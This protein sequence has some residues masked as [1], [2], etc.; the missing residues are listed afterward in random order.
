MKKIYLFLFGNFFF[1]CTGF[2]QT[3]TVPIQ[4]PGFDN[5]STFA[6]N[7]WTV[8][9][10]AGGNDWVVGSAAFHSAPNSAYISTDGNPKNY[11]YDNTKAHI[12]HFYQ[13][14]S[15]PANAMNI[16]FSFQLLGNNQLD[17][18]LT[19][20]DGLQIFADTSLT[21]PV[22]DVMP[23]GSAQQVFFQFSQNTSYTGQTVTLDALG[24]GGKSFLLI[25]TWLNDGDGAGSGPPASVD[26]ASI[27][28]CLKSSKFN[29]TG[30]GAFCTGSSGVG[31][32]LAGSTI[33]ISYQLYDNGT[34]IG[35]PVTGTGSA[36]DFGPQTAVGTYTV[37]GSSTCI[38]GTYTFPMPG[39]ATVTKNSLPVA[40][41][42]SNAPIC[43]GSTLNLTAGG[44]TSYKWI[45]PNGFTSTIQ[46]PAIANFS[47][48][49]TGTYTVTVMANGCSAPAT[50]RVSVTAGS[51][52]A[53]TLN[54]VSV[55]KGSNGKLILSGNSNN[56][57]YWQSTTDTTS[58]TWSKIDSTGSSL[59]LTNITIPAFYRAV[60]SDGC[61]TASSSIATV[62]IH[63]LWTGVSGTNWNDTGN[64]SDGKL[65]STSCPTV[66]IPV[67]PT[68]KYPLLSTGPIA[69]IIN[70]QIDANASLTIQGD[71][72]QIA[73]N[74]SNSGTFDVRSGSIEFN[75]GTPQNI[76]G[77]IF[78]THVIQNLIVSNATGLSVLA[79]GGTL[80]ISGTLSFGNA[81]GKLS[82]GDNITLLSTVNGTANTGVMSNTNTITGKVTVNRF[83]N[84]GT[85]GN[86]HGK[87]WQLLAT[88]TV[89][90]TIR[91][92]WMEGAAA[93][94]VTAK[95]AAGP[96]NP[97]PGYGTMTTSDV[98]NAGNFPTP[99]F[100][101]YT[102][103]GPSIKVYNYL[104]NNY[105]G[106]ANTNVAV[107][108]QHGYM[109]LV[110]GD[111]SVYQYNQPATPTIMRTT[112]V[113]F[114]P[115]NPPPSTQVIAGNFES[116][117]NPYAS[118]IDLH[119]ISKTGGV[120]DFY[121]V[122]DARLAGQYGL[123]AFQTLAKGTGGNYYA[124]PGG[125]SYAGISNTIQSGQAFFVAAKGSNGTVTFNENCKVGGSTLVLRE[126]NTGQNL[127][128]PAELRATL[129][130]ISDTA[131][132]ADGNLLQ[133]SA[134]YSN[135][136]DGMDARKMTNISENFGILSQGNMLAIERRTDIQPK[137]T[138]F[139]ALS[140][141][142]IQPYT[143]E[144]T[145]S[146]LSSYDVQGYVE[147]TYQNTRTL[148]KQ[149][150]ITEI[151]FTVTNA[152]GSYA[153]NRFRIVFGSKPVDPATIP[154]VLLTASEQPED[155]AVTWKVK[156][157]KAIREYEVQASMDGVNFVKEAMIPAILDDPEN[158]QWLDK[159]ITPGTH[160]YRLRY[161]NSSGKMSY[162]N[163]V[164][165]TVAYQNPSIK[166]YPNPV[167]DGIIHLQF[168]NEP[169]GRYLIRLLNSFGQAIITKRV[170]ITGVNVIE[171]ISWNY[172]LAHGI[173][174]L[175]I[176]KPDGNM[177]LIKLLY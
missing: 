145:T 124:T 135:K 6:A 68:N 140:G 43:F 144:F 38:V 102:Q 159:Q 52:V 48:A 86:A 167:T 81:N 100:D 29:V 133:Y 61:S 63:G 67:V 20:Q 111:R 44:G 171:K 163:A 132:L 70:L 97:N 134:D 87:S 45:G 142:R 26:D 106:P 49:D 117:G 17:N 24:L 127:S 11:S 71:T 51:A 72:L 50:T 94:N 101:V 119:N 157:G 128:N 56:P 152:A 137:D 95:G 156:N 12:S 36:L 121:Y 123:G 73:G 122:W 168:T 104:I 174:Q 35:N 149:E 37:A 139:Y 177:K 131:Y 58:G 173:Y 5:G 141:L 93:S 55:C 116:I 19:M 69:T 3:Y 89:G 166:I 151:N 109:I 8:V 158:Y 33:G 153:S 162:S 16:S 90:Q 147:D 34:P 164:Q 120:Q 7:G 13:K 47:S 76:S 160:Y 59:N 27:N 143:L 23:G 150:G 80:N 154:F 65:P 10:S 113:L 28:Y 118:A 14:I 96:A 82:T 2:A 169:E 105:V 84:T 99:G 40:T 85:V 92:S 57:E 161:S 146:G 31:V 46:N 77:S 170:E 39:S 62:G 155:I 98:A 18:N 1:L 60:V 64:W 53:G 130:G 115:A 112:G 54:A 125:G 91:E 75:G 165:V 41:A 126:E 66:Q 30:G 9:N 83:I 175:E 15:I 4:G 176:T 114:T 22:A 88:P 32:G 108:N 129:F 42:G 148:L 25:F 110:R 107:Y 78:Y 79:A 74:I 103:P 172:Y 138:I 21:P 136:I